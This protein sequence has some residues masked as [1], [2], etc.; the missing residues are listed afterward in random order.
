MPENKKRSSGEKIESALESIQEITI[1]DTP[2]WGARSAEQ[3]LRS[4]LSETDLFPCTFGVAAARKK[5][6]RL[7]YVDGTDRQDDW[8]RLPD[9]LRRYLEEYRSLSKETSL[10]VLFRPEK[11]PLPMDAYRERFWSVLRYLVAKDSQPWPAD[12]P[13]D[14]DESMWE[15]AFGGTPVFVVCN[16]PAHDRRRSRRADQFMI[17]FQPRW[18]FEGLEADTPRGAAARRTIRS[19]LRKYDA[20]DPSPF[21]GAYGDDDNRE[22]RQYFLEDD[23]NPAAAGEHCPFHTGAGAPVRSE[24]KAGADWTVVVNGDGQYSVWDAARALPRG[25]H[26]VGQPDTREAC[27]DRIAGLWPDPRPQLQRGAR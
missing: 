3:F 25:W 17:T 11:E 2:E 9:L 8:S 13:A 16:T 23:N 19:R 7:G 24:A 5:T 18:V 10:V 21:L 26:A 6:L 14:P 12:L 27:L 1:G 15:F 4:V 20:V 22:W